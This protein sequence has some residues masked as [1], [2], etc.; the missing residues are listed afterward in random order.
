[1]P[2]CSDSGRW[3]NACCVDRLIA[4][5]EASALSEN[6]HKTYE[7]G[8]NSWKRWAS[9]N[10][11]P[12]SKATA[13][14]IRRWLATLY[15]EGKK[16]ST[17]STYLAAATYK[18]RS[19]RG[20]NPAQHPR[21]RLLLAGL[22]RKAAE[23]GITTRQADPLRTE[24]IE[25]ITEAALTPRRNQPGGRLETPEQAQK[26]ADTDIALATTAH[27]GALRC[28]ELL[29][30]TWGNVE[31]SEHTELATIWLHRSKT[32]QRANGAAVPVS[33]HAALALAR[34]RPADAAP[35]DRVF[36]FSTS[37]ARRRLKAA[38]RTAGI[39]P[40]N[41]TTH[42]PRI[43]MA[44]DLAAAGTE[45]PGLMLAGRWKTPEI[46]ARYTKRIQAQHT[47]AAKYL[48]TQSQV[49]KD[50]PR[51]AARSAASGP[52]GAGRQPDHV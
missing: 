25:R 42:S 8:W 36:D 12:S 24:H 9:D 29:A 37:T 20:P 4:Q 50:T 47:P 13:D 10:K 27:D 21:V 33:E 43:G 5:A 22:I 2:L 49:K 38:A 46:A 16:P 26:R 30:I 19:Q 7:T 51:Q 34:I 40:A 18:L 31:L 3:S 17:L 28:S 11:Q 1:L 44:Q 41:I 14:G 45:M 39:N 6:T 35:S 15:L 48:K 32:D 52:R 23:E